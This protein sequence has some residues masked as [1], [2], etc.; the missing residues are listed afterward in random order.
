M[1]LRN[2]D[3]LNVGSPSLAIGAHQHI[4]DAAA[5]PANRRKG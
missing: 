4:L 1:R 2:A 3:P 5:H